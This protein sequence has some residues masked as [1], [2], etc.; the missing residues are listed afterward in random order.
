MQRGGLVIT[1]AKLVAVTGV[2]EQGAMVARNAAACT[3]LS[4]YC[5]PDQV[6]EVYLS[7]SIFKHVLLA[8]KSKQ[9]VMPLIYVMF[10]HCQIVL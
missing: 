2:C 6:T 8:V 3:S 4:D 10:S 5:V 1:G 9:C 7:L